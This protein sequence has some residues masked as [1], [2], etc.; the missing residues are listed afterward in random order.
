MSSFCSSFELKLPNTTAYLNGESEISRKN[1]TSLNLA[2][3][4]SV[5]LRDKFAF[6]KLKKRNERKKRKGEHKVK[7]TNEKKS[8][9]NELKLSSNDD[10]ELFDYSY[11]RFG[12]A[13]AIAIAMAVFVVTVYQTNQNNSLTG[14]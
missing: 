8:K 12:I 9:S 5:P 1:S 11:I 10:A 6:H 7:K 4:F 14:M 2:L 13:I 3:L